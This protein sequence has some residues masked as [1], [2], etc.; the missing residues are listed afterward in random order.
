MGLFLPTVTTDNL[1]NIKATTANCG[2]NVTFDGNSVMTASGVCWSTNSNPTIND[3]KTADGSGIGSYFSK[4]SNLLGNTTYYVR[5]YA[6]NEKGTS[7]GDEKCFTT[8]GL[9]LPM[10]TTEDVTNVRTHSAI[11]GGNVTFDGNSTISA[12]GICWSTSPNPTI[13]NNKTNKGS[14]T[15]AFSSTLD[16]LKDGTTYYVRAYATNEKGTAYGEEKNFTT[17]ASTGKVN[18]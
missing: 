9:F 15:G 13:N 8:L 3:N 10:V 7:Y 16:G 14:V 11:C 12:R 17:L 1:T 2:G 4:L 5:A 6:T 18:G